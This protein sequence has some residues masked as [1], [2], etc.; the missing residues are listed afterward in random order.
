VVW[1][2][3]AGAVAGALASATV[4][5]LLPVPDA[6]PRLLWAGLGTAVHR[7][8]LTASPWLWTPA[9][10][11]LATACWAVLGGTAGSLLRLAGPRGVG[12]L[13]A[14]ARPLSSFARSCGL[15]GVAAYLALS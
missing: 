1:G 11:L 10:V 3:L 13:A 5:C 7:L 6:L 9:W 14:G 4:A 2:T 12:V 15:P 8:G